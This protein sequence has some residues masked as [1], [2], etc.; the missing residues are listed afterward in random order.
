[1]GIGY[2]YLG[3][4]AGGEGN[5]GGESRDGE[6]HGPQKDGWRANDQ[7][8]RTAGTGHA[9][10]SGPRGTHWTAAECTPFF[11]ARCC[12]DHFPFF[13]IHSSV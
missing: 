2:W 5:G 11:M 7:H 10:V 4:C 13:C 12:E 3:T 6:N 9:G 8:A 1:M